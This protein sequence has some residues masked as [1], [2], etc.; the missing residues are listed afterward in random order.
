MKKQRPETQ[1][2]LVFSDLHG[3][4]LTSDILQAV[5]RLRG[6]V[7]CLAGD[8]LDAA[9]FSVFLKEDASEYAEEYANVYNLVQQL[10]DLGVRVLLAYGNHERRVL[11]WF[12]ARGGN[13]LSAR[14]RAL[15]MNLLPLDGM[16]ASLK[17]V[18]V[19]YADY[20]WKTATGLGFEDELLSRHIIHLGDAFIGHPSISRKGS[21]A[22]VQE[23]ARR[24]DEWRQPLS[25]PEGNLFVMGHTHQLGVWF[26][27]GGHR[28][29]AECGCAMRPKA[30]QWIWDNLQTSGM[31]P[32]VLGYISFEMQDDKTVMASVQYHLF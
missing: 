22:S 7:V 29:Y 25:L 19:A 4:P 9:A 11:K 28:A 27:R 12:L 24:M 10:S 13:T 15:A 2:V 6:K 21:A 18:D 32:P 31:G 14:D 17:N 16:A 20:G 5:K 26:T 30:A 3:Y 1:R 23:W 8:L